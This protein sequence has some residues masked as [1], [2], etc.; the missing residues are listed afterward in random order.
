[1]KTPNFLYGF[2]ILF[3]FSCGYS[4]ES[5][6]NISDNSN[7]ETDTKSILY[8]GKI[9]CTDCEGIDLEIS[10]EAQS[11]SSGTFQLKQ[12]FLGTRDGN[13]SFQDSGLYS[14]RMELQE[15]ANALVYIVKPGQPEESRYFEK[16]GDT[17]LRSLG[18]YGER[19]DSE[20]N[21]MLRRKY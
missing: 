18:N 15:D 21:Y 20:L 12:T 1:M 19:I 14:I 3:L 6:L 11:D 4:H 7:V 17:A 13:Q 5:T 10:F 8:Q 2:L 16:L 9:P